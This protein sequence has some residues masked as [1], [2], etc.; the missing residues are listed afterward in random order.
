MDNKIIY[1]KF[2]WSALKETHLKG[3]ITKVIEL[4]PD[5]VKTILDVGCGNGL[6]T[7]VLGQRYDVTGI[8]RSEYALSMVK[9]KKLKAS[10]DKIPL[11]DKAFDMVFSS[12]LLEHLNDDI[13]N[14]AVSEIKRLSKKYI[15]I[16]VPNDENPDKL[17]IK[18]PKCD[19]IYNSP[20]HLRSFRS[21]DFNTLFPEY[22][23]VTT[24]VFGTRVRYYQPQLLNIKK[25]ISPSKSWIPNYWM[26]ESKRKTICP[27]CEHE[28]ENTYNFNLIATAIDVLNVLISPKKPYWLFVLMEKK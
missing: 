12:E 1:E 27:Q 28:F 13:F 24:F 21:N 17:L 9:T 11:P 7:N 10:A 18:C 25:K 6:I 26:D 3:K 2:D 8:D 15:F 22:R 14:G 19:Y 20:N 23:I 4:I 16:T 5:D